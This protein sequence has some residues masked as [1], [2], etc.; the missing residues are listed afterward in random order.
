MTHDEQYFPESGEITASH[1]ERRRAERYPCS[2]QPFWRVEGQEQADAP[3]AQIQNIS[4]TGIG[5]RIGQPLKAGTVL[6]I[7]LQ[8]AD[9]RLSRPLP[10][11]VMHATPQAEGD[12][13][14]GCQFVRKL[15]DEDMQAVL[16][17][18]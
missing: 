17:A 11:R 3:P 5:L 15:S 6:V 16:D 7:K 4:A 1:P 18:E 9:R 14:V 8:S 10:A 2:L 13:L 12:W